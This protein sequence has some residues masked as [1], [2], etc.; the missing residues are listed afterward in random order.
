MAERLNQLK[1]Q[2]TSTFRGTQSALLDK[3][4]DDVRFPNHFPLSTA[5]CALQVV[6]VSALRTAITRAGK[7]GFKDSFPEDMLAGI[8]QVPPISSFVITC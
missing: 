7:G 4:A 6:I 2:I 5:D 8:L 3:S 1:N